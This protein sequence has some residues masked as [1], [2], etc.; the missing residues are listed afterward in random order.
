MN[1]DLDTG[2]LVVF[3]GG[4]ALLFGLETLFSKRGYLRPRWK[5]LG[6]HAGIAL[7]NMVT[8]RV[9]AYVP[10]LMWIV[11]V[12]QQGWGLRRVFG[13][14]GW[15]EIIVSIIVL[16]AFDYFWHRANH[17]VRFLWRFH[18]AHHSDNEMDVTTSLRFH[19]GELLIS[20]FVKAGWILVWGPTAVA[21]FLFEALV[22]LCAQFHH[23]NIDFPDRVERVLSAVIV[24]PRY[25]AAHHAVDRR[26]GDRNFSTIFSVWDRLFRSYARPA[27][28]G[29]TT[30]GKHAI[31]LPDARERDFSP[32]AVLTDPL[33]NDNLGLR[34]NAASDQP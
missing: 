24:T 18:K 7:F 16:D 29:E 23:A 31:G 14:V 10:L 28:G 13:L 17:R 4:F 34:S 32:V 25:H 33:R 9:L 22:S 12:E 2:K 19:P 20:A 11:Y 6:F 27:D 30:N 1:I 5:R 21:W 26:W 8:I 15:A 3:I